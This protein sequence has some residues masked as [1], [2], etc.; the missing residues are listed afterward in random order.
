MVFHFG[1]NDL[2]S[3]IY[4]T[5]PESTLTPME[6]ATKS[7]FRL[8]GFR[9]EASKRPYEVD[10][11]RISVS[12]GRKGVNIDEDNVS[13][14]GGLDEF[15]SKVDGVMDQLGIPAEKASPKDIPK[16]PPSGDPR[17]RSPNANGQN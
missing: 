7:E 4:Y 8:S 5:T 12:P 14:E 9:W 6:Q 15:E 1:N 11:M 2:D 17:R 10:K 13:E 3:I 16:K